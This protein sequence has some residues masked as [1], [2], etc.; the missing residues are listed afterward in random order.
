MKKALFLL[1]VGAVLSGVAAYAASARP[2]IEA[3]RTR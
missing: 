1:I 3:V 2:G